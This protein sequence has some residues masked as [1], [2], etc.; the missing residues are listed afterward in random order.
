MKLR[1][2]VSEALAQHGM[3][4]GEGD[5][6][7]GLRDRLNDRYLEDVRRLRARQRAGEIPLP[8][9][10]AHARALHEAYPLLG[11]PLALWVEPEE[12]SGGEADA[13]PAPLP[14]ERKR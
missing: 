11:L 1:A 14:H 10:A 13:A 6:P 8:E 12:S 7:G 9:Y 4:A 2:A 3:A 5:T